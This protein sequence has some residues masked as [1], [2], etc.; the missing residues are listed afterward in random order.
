MATALRT[1]TFTLAIDSVHPRLI[2]TSVVHRTNNSQL[3]TT[4]TLYAPTVVPFMDR[5]LLAERAMGEYVFNTHKYQTPAALT[6]YTIMVVPSMDRVSINGTT[7]EAYNVSVV[8]GW[9]LYILVTSPSSPITLSANST[10]SIQGTTIGAYSVSV[11][12]YWHLLIL[13]TS[14]YSPITL[15]DNSTLSIH[16]TTIGANNVS[17]GSDLQLYGLATSSLTTLYG[18][19]TL[20][21][22]GANRALSMIQVGVS[23]VRIAHAVGAAVY[24]R[25]VGRG[26]LERCNEDG[27]L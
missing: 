23:A 19:S 24:L 12:T 10:V 3:L 4:L 1:T 18:S 16:G 26:V 5:V 8:G 22:L 7:I 25:F 17:V 13:V 14:P 11:G 27:A 20:A 6:L 2:F 15:S 21:A 9:N